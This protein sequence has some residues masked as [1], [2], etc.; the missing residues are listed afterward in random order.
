MGENI[1]IV[2]DHDFVRKSLNDLLCSK[3]PEC[4]IIDVKTGEEAVELAKDI[5]PSV[6]IM[7]ISLPG[8]NGIE[9]TRQIKKIDPHTQVAILSIY[10]DEVYKKDASLAGASAYISKR[11]MNSELIKTIKMLLSEPK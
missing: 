5:L 2:E 3:F 1:L 7:D 10:E 8:I 11:V 4:R 6:V 9:A